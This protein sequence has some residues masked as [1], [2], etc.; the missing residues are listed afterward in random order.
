VTINRNGVFNNVSKLARSI[1]SL[2]GTLFP[3][4]NVV[5][6]T[7]VNLYFF[8]FHNQ[9]IVFFNGE[10]SRE[11]QW[12]NGGRGGIFDVGPPV[13][14][15]HCLTEILYLYW[16]FIECS[17]KFGAYSN[18]ISITVSNTCNNYNKN[19]ICF[20][21]YEIKKSAIP[22]LMEALLLQQLV[23]QRRRSILSSASLL[24]FP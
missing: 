23:V 1:Y 18:K 9:N 6:S 11:Y 5:I 24:F 17:G 16:F 20:I 14:R 10:M 22:L 4:Y 21:W 12:C 19:N 15:C 8:V 2:I 3:G 13:D 7:C